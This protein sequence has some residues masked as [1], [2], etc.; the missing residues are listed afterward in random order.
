MIV[1][2]K[3][4][5]VEVCEVAHGADYVDSYIEDAYYVDT[6]E[7]LTEQ[8]MDQLFTDRNDIFYE[9]WVNHQIDK[10]HA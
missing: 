3:G 10:A 4:R 6:E 2:F 7:Q 5:Q 8:E 1:I 9:D